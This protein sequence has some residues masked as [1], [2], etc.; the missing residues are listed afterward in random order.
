M[1]N[2]FLFFV[3]LAWRL[4]E[5]QDNLNSLKLNVGVCINDRIKDT[6]IRVANN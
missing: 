2:K 1:T 3:E 4:R 5:L 6:V